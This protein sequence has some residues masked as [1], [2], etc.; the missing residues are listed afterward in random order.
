MVSNRLIGQSLN[1]YNSGVHWSHWSMSLKFSTEFHH[2]TANMWFKVK[3][4]KVRITA[5]VSDNADWLRNLCEFL[6]YLMLT[7]G[8]AP[9]PLS[10]LNKQVCIC[11][12]QAE[13]PKAQSFWTKNPEN[14][15]NMTDRL[16]RS[17]GGLRVAMPSQLP[18]FL[19]YICNVF[20]GSRKMYRNAI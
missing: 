2:V 18:R 1:G 4:S 8:V 12:C 17:R 11:G 20:N 6:A 3:G 14:A 7:R 9:R 5:Y 13:L 19:V 16:A 15:D 10:T